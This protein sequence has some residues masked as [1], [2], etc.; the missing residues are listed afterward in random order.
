MDNVT[1]LTFINKMGGTKNRVLASLSREL[2]QWCLQTQIAVSAAHISG[3]LNVNADRESR[4]HLD[5]SDWKLC[6]AVFQAL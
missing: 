1:A 5:S 4:S 6:A 2:W 3:I